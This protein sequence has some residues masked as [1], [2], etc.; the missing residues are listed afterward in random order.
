MRGCNL[1]L[2]K[3]GACCWRNNAMGH[4]AWTQPVHSGNPAPPHTDCY[5]GCPT[6]HIAGVR[7]A[8]RKGR[9]RHR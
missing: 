9:Q 2:E 8:D 3:R 4:S 5:P 1:S 6:P 7:G